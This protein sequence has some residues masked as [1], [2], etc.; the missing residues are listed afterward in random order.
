MC[1][2]RMNGMKGKRGN[3]QVKFLP[4]GITESDDHS[5]KKVEWTVKSCVQSKIMP[6][7]HRRAGGDK[8]QTTVCNAA[9]PCPTSLTL[10]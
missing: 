1:M 7:S 4:H 3:E 8:A 9:G 10:E 2:L 5:E 6:G